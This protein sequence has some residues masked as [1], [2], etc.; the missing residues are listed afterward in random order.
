[1]VDTIGQV[2]SCMDYSRFPQRL[3]FVILGRAYERLS[4]LSAKTGRSIRDLAVDLLSQ[5]CADQ[6]E[7]QA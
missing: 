3:D 4:R 7:L 2:S 5:A 6:Q 1:M